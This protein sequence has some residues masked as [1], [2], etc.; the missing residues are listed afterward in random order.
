M[1]R[2]LSKLSIASG[3]AVWRMLPLWRVHARSVNP[4]RSA[5]RLYGQLSRTHLPF[6]AGN[7][8]GMT[9]GAL[10]ENLLRGRKTGEM[11]SSKQIH[12]VGRSLLHNLRMCTD[13]HTFHSYIYTWFSASINA[14]FGKTEGKRGVRLNDGRWNIGAGCLAKESG[15]YVDGNH[16]RFRLIDVSHYRSKT[17]WGDGSSP[18]PNSPSITTSRLVAPRIK[19]STTSV[20]SILAMASSRCLLSS[21]SYERWLVG[22]NR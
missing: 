7:K 2:Q 15:R 19:S 4:H 6:A 21:Q 3:K 5:G 12:K 22:L 14:S 10:C 11:S 16:S 8:Q 20:K 9:K 17:S 1:F 18:D 13:V